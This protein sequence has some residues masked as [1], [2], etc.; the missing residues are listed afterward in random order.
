MDRALLGEHA[1]HHRAGRR[2]IRVRGDELPLL[3]G[4]AADRNDAITVTVQLTEEHLVGLGEA[5]R[6]IDDGIE[7]RPERK[8]RPRHDLE[9]ARDRRLLREAFGQFLLPRLQFVKQPRILDGD[10]GLISEGLD[11]LDLAGSERFDL[12][13]TDDDD[14][15][16][17]AIAQ[18]RNTEVGSNLTGAEVVG[19]RQREFGISANVGDVHGPAGCSDAAGHGTVVGRDR[20]CGKVSR[21]IGVGIGGRREVIEPTIEPQDERLVRASQPFR[22]FRYGVEH[23]RDL[24]RRLGN[25]TEHLARRRLVFEAFGQFLLP[26]LEVVEEAGVLDGDDGLVG[27]GFDEGD[28]A[29][30]EAARLCA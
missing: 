28:L 17:D 27:E 9:H 1:P 8:L 2:R 15:D 7:H 19:H 14:A 23:R 16:D 22:R 30:G 13:A 11:K 24:C 18:Q 26:G 12:V 21:P 10:D 4:E 29:I 20:I 25:D 3:L 6:R 5:G